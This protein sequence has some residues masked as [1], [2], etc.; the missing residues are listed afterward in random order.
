MADSLTH[1]VPFSGDSDT[2]RHRNFVGQR[3]YRRDGV[4]SV[5]KIKSNNGAMQY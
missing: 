5:E 2:G 3:K 1:K 4:P